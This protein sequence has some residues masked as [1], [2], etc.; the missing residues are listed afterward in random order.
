MPRKCSECNAR[1]QRADGTCKTAGCPKFR[2]AQVGCHWGWRGPGK[3]ARRWLG[4]AAD[5]AGVYVVGGS[6][7]TLLHRHDIRVGIAS[8][9]FLK[10]F[11]PDRSRRIEMLMILYPAYWRWSTRDLLI[12]MHEHREELTV[13]SADAA[14]SGASAASRRADIYAAAWDKVE[15]TM[16]DK[17]VVG[18]RDE[19]RVALLHRSEARRITCSEEGRFGY[20][21]ISN[22][23]SRR[24]GASEAR[25]L[26]PDVRS[27]KLERVGK[28][29]DQQWAASGATYKH[30]QEV[31]VKQSTSLWKG[32]VYNRIRFLRWLF[33][34][35][36][37][38]VEIDPEEWEL[39]KYMGAGAEKGCE[40]A[41]IESFDD[42]QA[43]C[44]ELR[45][46]PAASGARFDLDDLIC[47]LCLSQ[48][49]E[50]QARIKL[51]APAKP[52]TVDADLCLAG[53][54]ARTRLKRKVSPLPHAASGAPQEQAARAQEAPQPPGA[55]RRFFLAPPC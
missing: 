21:P 7:L 45:K 37:M 34:A 13:P 31:L 46:L 2:C 49:R 15:A 6:A 4:E 12:A 41:G 44:A 16:R 18:Y 50:A 32:A 26:L 29:L 51:P 14:A 22:P 47:W 30:S 3:L 39:I 23:A 42:A 19:H 24:T 27:G 40:V 33:K 48:H 8:G 20:H 5:R 9:M 1:T 55:Q 28:A 17:Q 53:Q 10:T 11:V 36:G 38:S 54:G 35:E 52:V 25:I 43:A